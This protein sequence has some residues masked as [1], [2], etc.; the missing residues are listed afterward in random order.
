LAGVTAYRALFRRGGLTAGQKILITG[1]GGGAA[2]F[3]LQFAV[4][5]G[6]EVWVTSSAAA[7]IESARKRGAQGGVVYTSSDWAEEMMKVAGSFDLC[8]DSAAGSGWAGICRLLKPGGRLVFFGATQ[9][10]PKDIPMR[11][12]FF[13]QL[14]LLG[15]AMGSPRDFQDMLAFTQTHGIHPVIDAT[16]KFENIEEAFQRLDQ[17]LQNGKIVLHIG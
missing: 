4:A 16:F 10:A 14:S 2:Q 7:K 6:A 15:T 13:N 11:K 1:I 9:G 17:G 3:L 5:A 8:V 12:V